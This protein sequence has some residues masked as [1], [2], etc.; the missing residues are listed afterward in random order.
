MPKQFTDGVQV[1][2]SGYGTR[3][4]GVASYMEAEGLVD[5]DRLCHLLQQQIR[6]AER[7]Q[8]C[9]HLLACSVAAPLWKPRQRNVA[10]RNAD[11]V[12]RLLHGVDYNLLSQ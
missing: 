11:G 6:L 10:Q 4:K 12:F 3:C 2:A 5:A 8:S 9:K 1:T 7:G